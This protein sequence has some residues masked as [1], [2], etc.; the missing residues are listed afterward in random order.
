MSVALITKT[1]QTVQFKC[2]FLSFCNIY[3]FTVCLINLFFNELRT[4]RIWHTTIW[5]LAAGG[6]S[7]Q[8]FNASRAAKIAKYLSARDNAPLAPNTPLNDV[9]AFPRAFPTTV[10][11]CRTSV[12]ELERGLARSKRMA[13]AIGLLCGFAIWCWC[14]GFVGRQHYIANFGM[15]P[16]RTCQFIF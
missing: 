8:S 10:F 2:F 16:I 3:D 4:V 1:W 6:A 7:Q 14:D 13:Q 9:A 12:S 15:R 11:R 5:G